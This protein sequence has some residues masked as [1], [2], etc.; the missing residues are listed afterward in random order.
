MLLKEKI[1]KKFIIQRKKY[2]KITSQQFLN[3]YILP[4]ENNGKKEN[5]SENMNEYLINIR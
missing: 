3:K 4:F 5:I 2:N 1:N